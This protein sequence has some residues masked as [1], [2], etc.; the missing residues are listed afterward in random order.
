[1]DF[2]Q[3]YDAQLKE[4]NHI[5]VDQTVAH[6]LRANMT[7]GEYTCNMKMR[8][9]D[10]ISLGIQTMMN[11]THRDGLFPDLHIV[12]DMIPYSFVVDW[13]VPVDKNLSAYDELFFADG[14]DILECLFS[15]K[16]TH[17]YQYAGST[18]QYSIYCREFLSEFPVWSWS[19][20]LGG[21]AV[22]KSLKRT[23]D[24]FSLVITRL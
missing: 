22:Q 16:W 24:G 14:Y 18:I 21:F 4:F 2:E 8:I 15:Y 11:A 7:E 9:K 3:K 1:M 23:A 10:N 19:E 6:P 20:D 13:F 17:E 12:W 5:L